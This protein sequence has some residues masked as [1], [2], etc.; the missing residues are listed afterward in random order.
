[1]S[2]LD[3]SKAIL[4]EWINIHCARFTKLVCRLE[5]FDQ[6]PLT[7]EH[8]DKQYIL[9]EDFYVQSDTLPV[10]GED[11]AVTIVSERRFDPQ[12]EESY[13]TYEVSCYFLHEATLFVTF[14]KIDR[15]F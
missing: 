14:K 15:L 12:N 8:E 10:K 7:F 5:V 4:R 13:L 9:K 11:L 2:C 1:M 6:V 3:V